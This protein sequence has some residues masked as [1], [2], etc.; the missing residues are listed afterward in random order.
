MS[1]ESGQLSSYAQA[2][3]LVFIGLAAVLVYAFVSSARDGEARASCTALCALHPR[4][5]AQDRL[6]PDFELPDLD[7]NKVKLSSFR[8]KTVVL[9]FWTKTCRP[10]LEEMPTLAEL[11]DIGKGSGDFVVLGVSIDETGQDARATLQAALGHDPNFPVL[12]D[13]Q[14]DVV[15]GKFGTRLFPET[16]IIDP[17]GVIR[18]RVD[19]ARDW[20]NALVLDVIK[21]ASERR[22]CDVTFDR[23]KVTGGRRDICEDAGVLASEN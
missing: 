8:G 22:S 6:A 11:A 13:A 12:V 2:A 16:W 10:C 14:D 18:A 17:N 9:N 7:G 3:Q 20:S 15:L 4:Y 21:M 1:D 23:G 5:A 19:E